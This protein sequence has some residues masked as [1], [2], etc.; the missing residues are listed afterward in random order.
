ML[1]Y[2]S[3]YTSI[4]DLCLRTKPSHQ[5]PMGKLH[6]LPILKERWSVVLVD[7]ILELPDAYGYNAIMVVVDSVG[8]TV[9]FI[10]TTTTC[11]AMGAAN[12]YCKNVWN[13]HGLS[14]AFVSDQGPQ[15]IAK[16]TREL[17]C[18]FGIKLQASTAYHP[19][20]DG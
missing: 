20:S 16:F 15:F 5:T 17:Y 18:L 3:A 19:Q 10:P 14:N 7:F 8:K 6:P 1:H 2:I 12:L 11:S 13:L 9:H 4:C